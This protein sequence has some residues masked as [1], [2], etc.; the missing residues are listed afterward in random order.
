MNA[1]TLIRQAR[2]RAGLTQ[3]ELGDRSQKAGSAI[4]RWERREVEPSLATL[5]ELVNAAGFELVIGLAPL[6]DH[7]LAL[8]RRS[9]RQEPADR[10][11]EMVAAV[12]ALDR[13]AGAVG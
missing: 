3:R 12:R 4:S 9:L 11:A 6:D 2:R 13:M 1:G 10:L 8:V 7:D 5:R